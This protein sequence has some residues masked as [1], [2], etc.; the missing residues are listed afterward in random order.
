M[1][2]LF[3]V[4][5]PGKLTPKNISIH[6]TKLGTA[7]GLKHMILKGSDRSSGGL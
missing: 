3:F 4:L 7:I 2:T 6:N 1:L 5:N